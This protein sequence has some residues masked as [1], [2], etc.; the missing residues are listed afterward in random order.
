MHDEI[1]TQLTN[2]IVFRLRLQH[3]VFRATVGVNENVIVD[4]LYS[5]AA[6][7]IERL[8]IE[9]ETYRA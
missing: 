5:E 9:L 1:L 3:R 4:S 2:D 7:E 8:R 6:D